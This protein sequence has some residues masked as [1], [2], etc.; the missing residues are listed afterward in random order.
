MGGAIGIAVFLVVFLHPYFGRIYDLTAERGLVIGEE[1]LES[2]RR[3]VLSAEQEGLR[4]TTVPAE[5]RAFRDA[6]RDAHVYGDRVAFV[7]MGVVALVGALVG[8]SSCA[9]RTAWRPPAS[10]AGA[11]AG[12]VG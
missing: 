5:L 12:P 7:L 6:F 2:G 9:G 10:S 8:S 1:R 3:F 4:Q 11:R